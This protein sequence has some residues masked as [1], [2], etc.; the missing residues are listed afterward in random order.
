MAPF[1]SKKNKK[2]VILG[3]IILGVVLIIFLIRPTITGYNVYQQLKSMNYTVEDYGKNIEGLKSDLLVSSTNLSSCSAFNNELLTELE[4]YSDKFSECKNELGSMET[5][6]DFSKSEYEKTIKSLESDLEGKEGD[7][8]EL[9][10]KY[11]LL[12]KNAANNI[13]C[14]AKVD[15]PDIKYY[16]VENDRIV[17][18][19]EGELSISC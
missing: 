19:E 3:L 16:K 1:L 14:K 7:V 12:A 17:C 10:L 2:Y 18:L 8:D 4:K 11:D 5:N 15:N 13:C 6:F 9:N